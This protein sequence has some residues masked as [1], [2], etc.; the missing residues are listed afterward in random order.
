MLD[1]FRRRGSGRRLVRRREGEG[2][3]VI[4]CG[5]AWSVA[6]S[7]SHCRHPPAPVDREGTPAR[8]VARY[9]C[10]SS[11]WGALATLLLDYGTQPPALMYVRVTSKREQQKQFAAGSGWMILK[12]TLSLSLSASLSTHSC[13]YDTQSEPD[14]GK[15]VR[16]MALVRHGAP[17]RRGTVRC[18]TVRCDTVRCG[19]G[20]GVRHGV[21]RCGAVRYGG[22]VRY[23]EVRYGTVRGTGYGTV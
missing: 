22:E 2:G 15:L 7:S 21:V 8:R 10:R 5:N 20:Y 23:G 3:A 11:A 18:G 12:L 14:S 17:A 19:T 16:G 9:T 1:G 4:Q 13:M 6:R